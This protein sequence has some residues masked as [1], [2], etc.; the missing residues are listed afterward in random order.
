MPRRLLTGL[1]LAV[2][3]CC[4]LN[5]SAHSSLPDSTPTCVDSPRSFEQRIQDEFKKAAAV[6]TAEV[7][8]ITASS[9]VLRVDR[10]WKGTLGVEV[11]MSS[12]FTDN[13]DG[14]MTT[15]GEAFS[16]V[17][18]EKYLVFADGK[19]TDSL[20]ASICRPNG[21]LAESQRTVAVL[22]EIT[23]KSK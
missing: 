12:G 13:N 18:G 15:R 1:P 23:K 22:D 5:V 11:V 19:T 3:L 16:F 10:V 9:V 2:L 7:R 8:M 17:R 14:T 4:S 20:S 21:S 6:F